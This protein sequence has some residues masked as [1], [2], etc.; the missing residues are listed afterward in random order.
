MICRVV[1][2]ATTVRTC[3]SD[4]ILSFALRANAGEPGAGAR[5]LFRTH[6]SMFGELNER[7]VYRRRQTAM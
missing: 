3:A 5:R 7:Y 4:A 6:S 1:V 2:V